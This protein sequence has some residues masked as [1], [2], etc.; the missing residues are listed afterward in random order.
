MASKA[1]VY[2]SEVLPWTL[3]SKCQA[4]LGG[5]YKVVTFR[6]AGEL[7]ATE[8]ALGAALAAECRSALQHIWKKHLSMDVYIPGKRRR[9]RPAKVTDSAISALAYQQ[10]SAQAIADV[11]DLTEKR[12][13][14]RIRNLAPHTTD[15]RQS[16]QDSPQAIAVGLAVLRQRYRA[17]WGDFRT[18]E[19]LAQAMGDVD[20][21]ALWKRVV[22]TGNAAIWYGKLQ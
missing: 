1:Y 14:L 15:P 9:G 11:L 17:A 13:A 5:G 2:A 16:L 22:E 19:E 10:Y 21:E 4:V 12:V 7:T 8:Q 20:L 6:A 18:V 3:V